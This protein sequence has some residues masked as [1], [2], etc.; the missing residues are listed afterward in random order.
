MRRKRGHPLDGIS[1]FVLCLIGGAILRIPVWV[2]G[3]LIAVALSVAIGYEALNR[4]AGNHGLMPSCSCPT[5][6]RALG[7]RVQVQA[8]WETEWPTVCRNRSSAAIAITLRILG[9]FLKY[10]KYQASPV[11]PGGLPPGDCGRASAGRAQ[12]TSRP[13]DQSSL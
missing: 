7:P 2:L 6:A 5:H 13:T 8:R 1:T 3:A 4:L 9:H 12:K 11:Y 10:I